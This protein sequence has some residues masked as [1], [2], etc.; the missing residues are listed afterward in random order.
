MD[1]EKVLAYNQSMLISP[2]DKYSR[3][4]FFK[5]IRKET[6]ADSIKKVE[7]NDMF[8]KIKRKWW[9]ICRKND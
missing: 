2:W 1:L 6:I 3:D 4:L 7:K 5:M 8:K 9:K